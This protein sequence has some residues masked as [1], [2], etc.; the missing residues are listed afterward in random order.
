[1]FCFSAPRQV[2]PC[3]FIWKRNLTKFLRL[4]SLI[5]AGSFEKT[6]WKMPHYFLYVSHLIMFLVVLVYKLFANAKPWWLFPPDLFSWFENIT[7][8]VKISWV[9]YSGNF[10]PLRGLRLIYITA[11]MKPI[12]YRN[13]KGTLLTIDSFDV[14]K[15]VLFS[16]L[17]QYR[18]KYCKGLLSWEEI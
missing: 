5:F 1:M 16:F 12:F 17:W 15:A 8:K 4:Q 14:N 7:M 10:L 18:E 2:K 9:Y 11:I 13:V 3:I 6:L